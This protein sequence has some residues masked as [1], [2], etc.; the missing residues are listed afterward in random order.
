MSDGN[1]EEQIDRLIVYVRRTHGL[2]IAE[3]TAENA[4][5]RSVSYVGIVEVR[6]RDANTGWPRTV[7]ILCEDV[8][9]A[10]RH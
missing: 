1:V 4:I 2:I 10:I 3:L 7:R 6:G 8:W 9:R 5:R